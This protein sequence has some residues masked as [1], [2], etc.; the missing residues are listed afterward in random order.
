MTGCLIRAFSADAPPWNSVPLIV[1][2]LLRGGAFFPFVLL[3]L[4]IADPQFL[5]V[6]VEAD[7]VVLTLSGTI[8]SLYVLGEFIRAAQG[9]TLERQGKP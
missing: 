8:A 1:A 3:S 6:L 4:S 2:D 7:R 5:R 9:Y